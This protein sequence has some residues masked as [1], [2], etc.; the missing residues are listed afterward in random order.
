MKLRQWP[1]IGRVPQIKADDLQDSGRSLQSFSASECSVSRVSKDV[2][3][4]AI[5]L[6]LPRRSLGLAW[7]QRPCY[8]GWPIIERVANIRGALSKIALEA[9]GMNR[10]WRDESLL[11]ASTRADDRRRYAGW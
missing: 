4:L 6:L 5:L 11:S 1:V 8:R 7:N 9:A 3:Y 2:R 10:C